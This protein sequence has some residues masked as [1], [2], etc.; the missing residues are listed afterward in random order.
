M[1]DRAKDNLG[2]QIFRGR[3]REAAIEPESRIC[4]KITTMYL[5]YN[6]SIN[7]ICEN[8]CA[9]YVEY[10]FIFTSTTIIEFSFKTTKL[11]ILVLVHLEREGFGNS[12]PKFEVPLPHELR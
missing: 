4:D 12:V 9:K 5:S 6:I 7:L 11:L 3:K 1:E 10:V 2:N 8:H